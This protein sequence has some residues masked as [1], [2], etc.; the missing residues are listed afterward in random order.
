MDAEKILERALE[1]EK[2]AVE[3][4]KSMLKDASAEIKDLIE[5][6]IEE[7]FEHIK[8]I[9]DRLKALKLLKK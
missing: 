4:Y 5:L 8:L 7:E 2:R 1:I 9:E 3:F 6:L